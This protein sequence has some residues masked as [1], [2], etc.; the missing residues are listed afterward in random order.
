MSGSGLGVVSRSD[1]VPVDAV[2]GLLAAF[3]NFALVALGEAHW[4]QQEGDFV[5]QLMQH[6]GFARTVHTILGLSQDSI[7][8]LYNEGYNLHNL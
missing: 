7:Y 2:A 4:L 8:S 5:G 6:P 3:S 1:P